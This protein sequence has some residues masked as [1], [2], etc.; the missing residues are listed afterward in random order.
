MTAVNP[1]PTP[2]LPTRFHR[3]HLIGICGTAMAALAGMLKERGYLVSGSDTMAY[4]PV[5]DLLAGWGIPIQAGFSAQHLEPRPDLVVVGNI[6]RKD[7]PEVLQSLELGI[8][9]FSLPE[10]LRLLFLAGKRPVVI[11]GTHGKSTTSALVAW[12]L[13]HAGFDPGYLIGAV[14]L[15]FG[16]NYRLGQGPHFVVEGDEYDTAYFDKVPKFWHYPAELATINNIEYDHADI[17]PDIES[18]ER[19]FQTFAARVNSNGILWINGDCPRSRAAAQKAT[20]RVRSFGLTDGCDLTARA[21]CLEGNNTR[22]DLVLEGRRLGPLHSPLFGDHNLRNA[23]GSIGIALDAGLDL[24]QIEAALPGFLGLAKRQQIKGEQGGVLVIDD[25]AHHPTAVRETLKAIRQR[26]ADRRLWAVFEAKS[27]TSRRAVFQQE[28]AAAFD[29]A[30]R[31]IFSQ[32]W[33]KDDLP[34]SEKLSLPKLVEDIE[35]RGKPVKLIA[36]VEEIIEALAGQVRP[37]DVVVGL[38]GSD[39]GGFHAKLLSRLRASR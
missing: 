34:E 30:D 8:A 7:N 22:F 37:G 16:S 27:N 6:C 38:S 10:A 25:F 24:G 2:A 9:T 19:V 32:P 33:K 1:R 15:N 3:V 13:A 36:T 28:Y 5:S 35:R 23:L 12:L 31:V 14:P 18:I 39:F 11:T 26:F 20:A 17:Y 21:V 29:A 4:P